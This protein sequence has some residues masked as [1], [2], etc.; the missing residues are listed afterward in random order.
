MGIFTRVR[1]I[2]SANL[3]A[4]LDKAEDPEKLIRL[5]IKEM[6]DTL[7]EIKASCAGAMATKK[8]IERDCQTVETRATQ[9][10]EKAQL[11]VDKGREDLAREALIEKR[12]YAERTDTLKKEQA[13]CE[14]LIQQYQEDITQLE[15][16]LGAVREKQR[17]LI[18]RHIH[19]QKRKRAQEDLRRLDS[20]DAFVRFEQFE[21][22]IERMEAEADLVNPSSNSDR[23]HSLKEEF[24]R[25][26]GDEE[27]E[28][29]LAALKAA[30][31]KKTNEPPQV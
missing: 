25:L 4:M 16:K 2:I 19:A 1:D 9:W 5:M 11:A 24:A 6:E 21:N 29:E 27:I 12:R 28:K 22:R 14:A 20:S 10:G 23:Q 3:N 13:E 17:L 26:E 18:Q 31:E 7:V 8:K 30:V 15:N